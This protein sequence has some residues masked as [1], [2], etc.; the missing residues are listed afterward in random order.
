LKSGVFPDKMK[1]A[2]V[3]LLCKKGWKTENL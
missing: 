1:I 2:E 3:R